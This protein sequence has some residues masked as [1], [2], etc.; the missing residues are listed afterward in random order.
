MSKQ[1]SIFEA[2][3]KSQIQ[4]LTEQ[5]TKRWEDLI[6]GDY[7][8]VWW[9]NGV[10]FA[11]WVTVLRDDPHARVW[12]VE[13]DWIDRSGQKEFFGPWPDMRQWSIRFMHLGSNDRGWRWIRHDAD[14][15][16]KPTPEELKQ[17]ILHHLASCK[18]SE[19]LTVAHVANSLWPVSMSGEAYRLYNE[20]M[21]E[22]WS[23]I[24][25]YL[26][27]KKLT[28]YPLPKP[29]TRQIK[30]LVALAEHERLEALEAIQ[31]DEREGNPWHLF[32]SS[33]NGSFMRY[34]LAKTDDPEILLELALLCGHISHPGQHEK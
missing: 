28:R 6:P 21:I 25:A 10:H 12:E 33:I 9:N 30:E 2:I 3:E 14:Y 29:V 1:L 24:R 22:R 17:W 34:W 11:G 13:R 20:A 23:N 8:E 26:A 18:P 32:L 4:E 27:D 15:A 31:W 19:T 5:N 7:V 16:L